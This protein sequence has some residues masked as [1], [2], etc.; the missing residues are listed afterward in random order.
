VLNNNRLSGFSYD[1]AG[2]MTT[3]PGYGSYTYDAENR[4]VTANGVTYTYDGD[5]RRVMKSTGKLYWYGAGGEVLLEGDPAQ[6]YVYDEHI[7]FNGQRIA[8]RSQTSQTNSSV[9]YFFSDHLGS[10]R[11]V[12]DSAGTVVEDSDFYP[13]GGERVVLDGL[14]NNYKFTGHER[15]G[16]SGLDY[17]IARHYAFT[18]GRF[19]QPDPGPFVLRNAQSL[20]RYSYALNNPL[21]FVDPSGEY[22]TY[23]VDEENKTI[24]IYVTVGLYGPGASNEL[25]DEIED[26][27]E[28]TWQGTYTDPETGEQYKV[29][30]EATVQVVQEGFPTPGVNNFLYVSEEVGRAFFENRHN[31]GTNEYPQYRGAIFANTT[32]RGQKHETGH[33]LGLGDGYYEDTGRPVPGHEGTIMAGANRTRAS[34][35]EIN[36]IAGYIMSTGKTKG[37]IIV[38]PGEKTSYDHVRERDATKQQENKKE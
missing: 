31:V 6:T 20:N 24:T 14:N 2:N 37:T 34:Q 27:I 33:M 29:T 10:S 11:I 4:M 22:A 23:A 32:R 26:N 5:G 12:T 17:F 36:R 9:Y 35:N 30:T 7:Y 3:Y 1:A 15:D 38:L 19:L 21:R 13:F 28:Q 18:L 8:R 16:E 25:A